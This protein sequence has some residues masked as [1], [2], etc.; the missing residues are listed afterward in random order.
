MT[1]KYYFKTE[2]DAENFVE[3]ASHFGLY[4]WEGKI[5][6]M[7]DIPAVFERKLDTMSKFPTLAREL[8]R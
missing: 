1:K 4:S 7:I 8:R 3:Y 2:T 5:V 6:T